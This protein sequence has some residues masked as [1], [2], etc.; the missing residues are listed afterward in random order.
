MLFV[1]G[2]GEDKVVVEPDAGGVS[3]LGLLQVERGWDTPVYDCG[4]DFGGGEVG[5][6]DLSWFVRSCVCVRELWEYP[7]LNC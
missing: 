6:V 5:I 2:F 3:W 7:L 1:V 4:V